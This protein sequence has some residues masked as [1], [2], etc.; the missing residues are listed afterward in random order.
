MAR[1]VSGSHVR[2]RGHPGSGVYTWT[3]CPVRS[4]QGG[5]GLIETQGLRGSAF[6]KWEA[7]GPGIRGFLLFPRESGC[8]AEPGGPSAAPGPWRAVLRVTGPSGPRPKAVLGRALLRFLGA[9]PSGKCEVGKGTALNRQQPPHPHPPWFPGGGFVVSLRAD[10]R[11]TC[12][13]SRPRERL[14]RSLT[15]AEG[16]SAFSQGLDAR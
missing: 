8:R 1:P 13:A 7:G 11:D 9:W 2:P 5:R 6:A 12:P 14:P 3:S 4:P 10:P 16:P 15:R